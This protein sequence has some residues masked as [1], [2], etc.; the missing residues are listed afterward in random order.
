MAW[1]GLAYLLLC[2]PVRLYAFAAAD[3]ALAWAG[4][5]VEM[6]ML[7]F[8]LD[9]VGVL[10]PGR[11]SFSQRYGKQKGRRQAQDSAMQAMRALHRTLR[12]LGGRWRG[13]VQARVRIGAGDAAATALAAGAAQ[14]SVSALLS[15]LPEGIRRDVR[16]DADAGGLHFLAAARCIWI[17]RVGDIMLAAA[18]T[19][20]KDRQWRETWRTGAKRLR[21]RREGTRWTSIPSRA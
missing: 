8:R 14:A 6:G 16:I 13:G 5:C 17:A 18:K 21:G 11:A 20:A 4:V 9:G 15:A 7:C 12:A 10:W 3:G 1:I 19:A 2:A